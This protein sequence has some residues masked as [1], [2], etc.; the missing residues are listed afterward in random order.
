MIYILLWGVSRMK[1]KNE[2]YLDSLLQSLK[3]DANSGLSKIATDSGSPDDVSNLGDMIDSSSEN[4]DLKEIGEMLGSLESGKLLDSGMES[5][6]DSISAPADNSVPKYKVGEEISDSYEKDEDELALDKAIAEAEALGQGDL[7]GDFQTDNTLGDLNADPPIED[8]D[9]ALLEVAP[10]VP[11]L[12][13]FE[14][15]GDSDY[16]ESPEEILDDMMRNTPAE[17]LG[18]DTTVPTESSDEMLNIDDML[19]QGTGDV[20]HTG[21]DE[22]INLDGIDLEDSKDIASSDEVVDEI[23][24]GEN[25]EEG[26]D[27][28]ELKI[29]DIPEAELVT[30]N[31][32]FDEPAFDEPAA[33]EIKM[34]DSDEI[35]LDDMMSESDLDAMLAGINTGEEAAAEPVSEEIPAEPVV[36]DEAPAETVS[37][38]IFEEEMADILNAEPSLDEISAE[39]VAETVSDE[40]SEEEMAEL[41]NAEPSLDDAI[42]EP[43][44]EEGFEEPSLDEAFA[45]P[46]LDE[47]LTEPSLDEV[48][49]ESMMEEIPEVPVM[50]DAP[51]E[52][53]SEAAAEEAVEEAL[54]EESAEEAVA[55]AASGEPAGET[56][57][58]PY[59]NLSQEQIANLLSGEEPS[60][61]MPEDLNLDDMPEEAPS[62]EAAIEQLDE[63]AL[64]ESLADFEEAMSK[65]SSS[66]EVLS[67]DADVNL[68]SMDAELDNLLKDVGDEDGSDVDE[69]GDIGSEADLDSMLADLGGE[70]GESSEEGDPSDV[71]MPDLDAF[72]NSLASDDIEDLEN[73]AHIDEKEG[74]GADEINL[75]DLGVNLGEPSLDDGIAE[76]SDDEPSPEEIMEA[77][78]DEGLDEIGLSDDIP[79]PD[80]VEDNG[81]DYDEI[82][83]NVSGENPEEG[84]EGG[85]KKKKKGFLAAIFAALI[86]VLTQTD[87]DLN[88]K[89]AEG[90]LAS[91]TDENQQVLDELAAEDKKGKKEKKKKEKKEKKPKKE[92]P[93]KEKKQKPPKE[94]KPKKEKKKKVDDGQPE[95]ALAPKK[96]AIAMLFAFSLGFLC[97]LPSILLPERIT[98]NSAQAAI[99]NQDYVRAYQILYG[100]KLNEEQTLTYN[101]ARVLARIDYYVK[102][103]DNF[104]AM[105]MKDEAV[106]SLLKAMRMKKDIE[107]EADEFQVAGEVENV[108]SN[109]ESILA[110]DYG[111]SIQDIEEIN[112]LKEKPAYTKRIMEV[113][114]TLKTLISS[115]E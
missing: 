34:E 32:S 73:T 49:E 91:L 89:A 100:Q 30:D 2:E 70:G 27:L 98:L 5:V 53:V 108:Y 109:I 110:N 93:P 18:F 14:E 52:A 99:D 62:E 69:L 92:K 57:E 22:G 107:M 15:E 28:E 88:P 56:E 4:N 90:E 40:M 63:A 9:D 3:K 29:E 61:K 115:I 8:D 97:W 51:E 64:E 84:E 87:E 94:K 58:D 66:D 86:K 20:G 7:S 47:A 81:G 48:P 72:M 19:D 25:R 59:E 39:P 60:D 68:E 105:N 71:D 33:E 114:G 26:I 77:L 17:A 42:S 21:L 75:D 31:I 11:I 13:D 102:A 36:A 12:D 46:T 95:K 10:E 6:L 82:S 45:E 50:E 106:D 24:L 79:D 96:V 103:Y 43:S 35:N 44:L 85:K 65:D 78:G 83:L 67:D 54:S 1:S 16:H 23:N 101:Q 76:G 113:T 55:E 111:L 74:A 38:E 104:I 112:A 37:D 80:E 41:L